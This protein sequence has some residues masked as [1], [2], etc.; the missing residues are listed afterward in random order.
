MVFII[1][2]QFSFK[3]S[4]YS[5]YT[6]HVFSVHKEHYIRTETESQTINNSYSIAPL[7]IHEWLQLDIWDITANGFWR[8]KKVYAWAPCYAFLCHYVIPAQC[9]HFDFV[10]FSL[11]S[12]RPFSCVSFDCLFGLPV[13]IS[14]KRNSNLFFKNR[15][16][17]WK[18]LHS[19]DMHMH[20]KQFKV[21]VC[22]TRVHSWNNS[23]AK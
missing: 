3:Q 8:E 1:K 2:K 9:F 13:Q 18:G 5:S 4:I 14:I 10:T 23:E 17:L 11:F 16:G 7:T 20:Q 21:H 6:E 15:C 22:I 19:I 12:K